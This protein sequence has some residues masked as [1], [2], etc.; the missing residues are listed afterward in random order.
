MVERVGVKAVLMRSNASIASAG[1]RK[2]VGFD[3]NAAVLVDRAGC[4]E[5][6]VLVT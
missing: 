6:S 3:Q 2:G 5:V 4:V 1:L